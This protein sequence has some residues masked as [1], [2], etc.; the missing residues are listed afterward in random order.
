MRDTSSSPRVALL[1]SVV[2]GVATCA[3]I[4]VPWIAVEQLVKRIPWA[5]SAIETLRASEL[6][7]LSS[8]VIIVLGT[9][10]ALALVGFVARKYLW[11]RLARVPLLATF[12]SGVDQVSGQLLAGG[13]PGRDRVVWVPWPSEEL[14]TIG[15]LTGLGATPGETPAWLAVVMFPTAGR[16]TGGMLRRVRPELVKY[17]GWS[18]DEALAFVSSS[19]AQG[20]D[21]RVSKGD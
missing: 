12:T 17:S 21:A 10:L 2:Y 19:G 11:D 18:I 9:V 14:Q 5:G 16:V 20:C 4:L 6:P 15:V 7:A 8:A 1:T 3:L 13:P